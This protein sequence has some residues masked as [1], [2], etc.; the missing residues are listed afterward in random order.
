MPKALEKLNSI[1]F[2]KLTNDFVGALANILRVCGYE[3]LN[4]NTLTPIFPDMSSSDGSE[5]VRSIRDSKK[6]LDLQKCMAIP[7]TSV[8][9][10]RIFKCQISHFSS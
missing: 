5:L 3:I 10:E 1:M 2:P 6:I 4:G 8:A 9:S 7:A